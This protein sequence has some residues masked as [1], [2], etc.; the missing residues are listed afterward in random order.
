MLHSRAQEPVADVSP[1]VFSNTF[2]TIMLSARFVLWNVPYPEINKEKAWEQIW[3]GLKIIFLHKVYR[4]IAKADG[5]FWDHAECLV[6]SGG[7]SNKSLNISELISKV[8]IRPP[9]LSQGLK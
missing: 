3:G 8:E 2:V 1:P 6:V 9:E 5:L 7:D 4:G